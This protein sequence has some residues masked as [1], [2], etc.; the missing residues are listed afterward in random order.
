MPGAVN[1]DDAG[2]FE[3]ARERVVRAMAELWAS[4]G[5]EETDLAEVA[6]RAEVGPET[7]ADLFADKEET[8]TASVEKILA[9]V[10]TSVSANYSAD[11]AERDSYLSAIKSLLELMAA[12]PS[13][14]Y[15]A[16]IGSRHGPPAARK[17]H[18]AGIQILVALLERLG[19]LSTAGY[20]PC[21]A[22]GALGG[23]EAVVRREVARGRVENLPHLLPDFVYSATVPFLGQEEA[24]RLARQARKLSD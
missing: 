15:V 19:D 2:H 20:P 8:A 14:A 5:Y 22:R 12:R 7:L 17:T 11:R 23:P 10:V 6:E 1:A 3:P 21:S 24:M 4:R 13:F 16:Y 9:D 18:A